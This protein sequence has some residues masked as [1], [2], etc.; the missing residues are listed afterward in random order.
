MTVLL[1]S[2]FINLR[3]CILIVRRPIFA[4]YKATQYDT[5]IIVD[6][7]CA[8]N[9]NPSLHQTL[10]HRSRNFLNPALCIFTVDGL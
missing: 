10:T 7:P 1:C 8:D 5:R 2:F 4:R 9:I 6:R 3:A